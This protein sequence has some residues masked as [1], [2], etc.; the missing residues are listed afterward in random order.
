MLDHNAPSFCPVCRAAIDAEIAAR[1]GVDDGPPKCVLELNQH[2]TAMSGPWQARLTAFDRNGISSAM[3][4]LDGKILA[5][6]DKLPQFSSSS[7]GG[8]FAPLTAGPHR[9][10]IR[11][12]DG[13]GHASEHF[14][15]AWAQ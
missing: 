4:L 9:L 10:A 5:Q 7:L 3:L 11:C 6:L 14:V 8:G 2:P 13:L 1:R 15:D 12:V